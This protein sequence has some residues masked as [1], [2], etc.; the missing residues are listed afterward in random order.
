MWCRV[1]WRVSHTLQHFVSASLRSVDLAPP[2]R[3]TV[4]YNTVVLFFLWLS[5]SV[6]LYVV[7]VGFESSDFTKSKKGICGWTASLRV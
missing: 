5:E 7:R 6:C 3:C 2:V 4:L 1:L